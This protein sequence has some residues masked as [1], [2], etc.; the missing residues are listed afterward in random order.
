ML[1]ALR[2]LFVGGA[3]ATPPEAP[4]L[5]A[6]EL[7]ALAPPKVKPRQQSL[8]SYLT[9]AKTQ[10]N[11]DLPRNDRALANTDTITLRNGADTRVV[12]R[13]L[14]ASNPDLSAAVFGFL[15]TAITSEYKLVARNMDG[16]FNREAT[17]LAQQI[18]TRFDEVQD[19]SDGFSGINSIRSTSESLGKEVLQ[20]GAMGLELVLDKA[21]LPR[22][23][24]P[25][26]TTQILMRQDDGWLK[27]VQKVGQEERDLDIPTFFMVALDQDLLQPYAESPLQAAIQ[28]VLADLDFFNDLRRLVKRALHPRL[29]VAINEEKFRKTIP[30]DAALDPEKLSAYVKSV[31]DSVQEKI[32]ALNPEDALVHFDF[33]E[34]SFL[35]HGNASPAQEEETLLNIARSRVASG[36]KTMP[37]ILGHGAGTQ[38]VASTETLL[39]MASAVGAVQAKLDE[40][41]SKA[42]TLA[43]RLFGMD[44]YV[45]FRYAPVDLRPK[46]ELEAF[47]AMKQS[48]VLEQLSLGFITD[49][50]ACIELTG[51]VTPAG[52]APL[53][54][55]RF[56]DPKPA[57]DVAA[58]GYSTTGSQGSKEGAA[59][60][61]RTPDTPTQPKTA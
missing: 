37:S 36:S 6:A 30:Q 26:S 4:G 15:R 24:S 31:M 41:Y 12:I 9:R 53:S 29:D 52:F 8:P 51:N 47:F 61:S 59:G 22:A 50:E 35:N 7:P 43:V 39:F 18:A 49:D 2:R 56:K 57:G 54:G 20:Y 46:N 55:T 3:T 11:S 34:V 48:R 10:A 33:I 28:P 21:R 16:S 40:I 23:L 19:Y 5:Q 38:N 25:V 32:N 13:D 17:I 42:F 1:E 58:N 45:E 44:V 27:P 60:K 14:V